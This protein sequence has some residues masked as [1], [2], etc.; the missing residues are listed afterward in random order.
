MLKTVEEYSKEMTR[1]EFDRFTEVEELCPSN[2]GLKEVD[3]EECN[4]ENC[5]KCWNKAL[6]GIEFKVA[7]PGL[8]YEALNY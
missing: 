7:L 6:V 1:E 3:S 4:I 8:P 2:L 5:N